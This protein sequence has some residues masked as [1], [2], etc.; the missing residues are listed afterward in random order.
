LMRAKVSLDRIADFLKEEELE[1]YGDM[2]NPHNAS[3]SNYTNTPRKVGK[4]DS[5]VSERA[6]LLGESSSSSEFVLAMEGGPSDEVVGLEPVQLPPGYVPP[7]IGFYEGSFMYFGT[8]KK[9]AA[10]AAAPAAVVAPKPKWSWPW[11]SKTGYTAI[12]STDTAAI[13]S[14]PPVEE[15]QGAFELRN[16]TLA[17]PLG[18][19]SIITGATGSGKSS[20]LL[21]LLGELKCIRGYA[22]L[23][24]PRTHAAG[25]TVAYVA[26]TAFLLNAT[27]R[28]NILFGSVYEEGRYKDVIEACA[29]VR[30]LEILEGGDLTE[31]GEK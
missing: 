13:T 22:F 31:I 6:P 19:L 17:F 5:T 15:D 14:S 12:P 27:I 26:Q 21:S 18:Q 2:E 3:I 1:K 30:D 9:P 29:L 8:D 20:L 16:A 10:V 23:P 11:T 25:T 7:T 24:D 28:E 4:K